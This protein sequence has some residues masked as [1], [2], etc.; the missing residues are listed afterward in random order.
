MRYKKIIKIS[1]VD[2]IRQKSATTD[3]R[4]SKCRT[5]LV[6]K[7]DRLKRHDLVYPGFLTL[8]IEGKIDGN[9]CVDRKGLKDIDQVVRDEG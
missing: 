5:C 6:S 4:G 3:R 2:K 8:L 7:R 9:S 1:G